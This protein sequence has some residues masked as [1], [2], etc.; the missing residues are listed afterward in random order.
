MGGNKKTIFILDEA[1]SYGGTIEVTALFT[2]NFSKEKYRFI[3]V[4]SVDASSVAPKF[5]N[6]VEIYS[7]PKPA[8]YTSLA[9]LKSKIR[10]FPT[11]I[12]KFVLYSYAVYALIVNAKYYI[13]VC[14]V[15][16]SRKPD[17]IHVNNGYFGFYLSKLS[18]SPLVLHIHGSGAFSDERDLRFLEQ[19]NWFIA[20][21]E[22]VKHNM[23]G[24]GLDP[25]KISVIYNAAEVV[26]VPDAEIKSLKDTYGVSEHDKVI[27]FFGRV[28]EW[29]GQKE[30]LLA[31]EKLSGYLSDFKVVI[32]GDSA[33]DMDTTYIDR[34]NV[35]A[36]QPGLAGKII[37]AG[38]QSNVHPYYEISDLIVH[39]SIEPEPFGLVIVEAMSHKKPV[40][41]S[42]LGTPPEI[43][44]DGIEGF[45]LNPYNTELMAEKMHI[46][47]KDDALAR[48]M[49]EQGYLK[50][51]NAFNPLKQ[52][53]AIETIY[54]SLL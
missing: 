46:L 41:V 36:N 9:R 25:G 54:D 10:K 11:F 34:L 27:G 16:I 26:D 31:V 50:V 37:F 13:S 20:I 45:I 7:F 28:V 44:T 3:F 42:D 23:V 52:A 48:N 38:Y 14:K 12:N 2:R 47:L 49:G 1:I 17:L 32:V 33:D 21:S 22:Y 24:S 29:K 51:V 39:A 35:L 43:I 18:K 8:N 30:F 4:T 19:C 5:A 40:I 15:F 53:S 6:N